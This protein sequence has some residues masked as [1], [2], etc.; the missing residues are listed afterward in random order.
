MLPTQECDSLIYQ[1]AWHFSVQDMARLSTL[2]S[3]IKEELAATVYCPND[4]SSTFE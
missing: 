1:R 3:C 2:F 4:I